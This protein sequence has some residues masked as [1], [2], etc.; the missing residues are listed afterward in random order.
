MVTFLFSTF[1]ILLA[2]G[3]PIGFVLALTALFGFIKIDNPIY[4]TMI[5]QR[6]FS[7]MDGFSFLALPFF[8]LAGDIMNKIGITERLISFAMLFFG[9]LRGGLAQ[10]NIACS[11]IFGGI[12]GAAMADIAALGNLFISAMQKEG[13]SK[14]FA[15]ALIVASSIIAPIIPPSIIMVIYGA[16]MGVSIA[17]LFASGVLP[18]LLI[19]LFLMIATRIISGKRNYPRHAEGITLKKVIDRTRHAFWALIMPI[20]I[21]GGILGGVVTPTEAAAIAVGYALFLGFFIYRNLKPSDLPELIFKN[22]VIM[23]VMAVIISSASIL[24]WLLSIEKIPDVVAN[25]LLSVSHDKYIILLLLNIIIA[26]AGCF[27]DITAALLLLAPILAPVAY[28]VGVAP[29]H[30]GIMMCINLN[31]GLITPPVG[32]CLFMGMIMT[33]L[34]ME[35]LVKELWPFLLMEMLVLLIVIY[36]PPLTMFIPK[37]LG[38]AL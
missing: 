21:L 24:A 34:S 26:I 23:G 37:M 25:L 4:L 29:L 20:I 17:G 2:I 38:F 28:S 15:T 19:G 11:V 36:F 3:M 13:Y 10:V 31:I 12:S 6:F 14:A 32:A 16:V 35:E 18:G 27:M 8:L 9:R 7:S 5:P 30:F 22:A 1:G 33:G